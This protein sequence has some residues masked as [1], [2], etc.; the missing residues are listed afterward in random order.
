[1]TADASQGEKAAS[2]PVLSVPRMRDAGLLGWAWLLG[3]GSRFPLQCGG[4]PPSDHPSPR[5]PHQDKL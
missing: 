4:H 2:T 1:M 3:V 5:H